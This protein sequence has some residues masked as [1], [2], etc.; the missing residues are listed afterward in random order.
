[1]FF[2]SPEELLKPLNAIGT[3]LILSGIKESRNMPT[4]QTLFAK[5][6]EM[7]KGG[8]I[9]VAYHSQNRIKPW[10]YGKR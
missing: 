1:M 10:E 4:Q 2:N 7:M 3:L 5:S 6:G 8:I 9:Y